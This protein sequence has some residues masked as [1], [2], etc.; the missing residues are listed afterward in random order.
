MK[1][2]LNY[3]LAIIVHNQ[4]NLRILHWKACGSHYDSIHSRLDEYV[5]KFSDF[6]DKIAEMNL[7][8]GIDPLNK[9]EIDTLLEDEDIDNCLSSNADYD[10]ERTDKIVNTIF[11][12]I[13]EIIS[14]I[15]ED[16]EYPSYIISDLDDIEGF[17]RLEGS[18]KNVQRLN[19]K[20]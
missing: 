13:M 14:D 11:G 7:M 16:N 19:T 15:R 5:S 4:Y 8:M 3:L 6:I 17:F 20:I 10:N 9:K 12:S 18:Y 1:K 2:D